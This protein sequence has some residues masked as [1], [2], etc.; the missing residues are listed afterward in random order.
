MDRNARSQIPPVRPP[1]AESQDGGETT[2]SLRRVGKRRAD[3]PGA[4]AFTGVPPFPIRSQGMGNGATAAWSSSRV[5]VQDFGMLRQ[6]TLRI[7]ARPPRSAAGRQAAMAIA[8]SW[9]VRRILV[10]LSVVATVGCG[11][12]FRVVREWRAVYL[13]R[14]S[15]DGVT[16][17]HGYPFA[18]SRCSAPPED[19][20]HCG[21]AEHDSET[22]R[23][24][25]RRERYRSSS[26]TTAVLL[27]R[28]NGL[29]W[30]IIK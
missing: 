5:P 1:S 13:S 18:P 9:F 26:G 8:E 27:A 12:G 6:T 2:G 29:Y 24:S 22:G 15:G 14:A 4:I 21:K 10:F 17:S 20:R 3:V 7:E 11:V 28:P 23:T 16:G 30:G 25:P 19:D